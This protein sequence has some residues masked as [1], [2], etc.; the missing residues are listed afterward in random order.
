MEN[1]VEIRKKMKNFSEMDV[2]FPTTKGVN[3]SL[4]LWGLCEGTPA[5]RVKKCLVVSQV[6]EERQ[7]VVNG[8][9]KELRERFFS[10]EE[11][12]IFEWSCEGISPTDQA[13]RLGLRDWHEVVRMKNSIKR[14]RKYLWD[15]D[16]RGVLSEIDK[17]LLEKLDAYH[18]GKILGNLIILPREEIKQKIPTIT[19]VEID[20]LKS[21]ESVFEVIDISKV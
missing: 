21:L 17:L 11:E 2:L 7:A 12:Q 8:I 6:F 13:E 20:T 1:E 15:R 16:I 4:F 10:P 19:D 9:P 5:E 18:A 14:K 3:L